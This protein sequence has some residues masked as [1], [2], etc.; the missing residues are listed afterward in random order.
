MKS[1]A[2]LKLTSASRKARR[3]SRKPSLTFSAVSRPRPRSFLNASPSDRV[4]PSNMRHRL[5]RDTKRVAT[6]TFDYSKTIASPLQLDRKPRASRGY[7]EREE[8]TTKAQS[9]HKGP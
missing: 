4:M 5:D 8:F 9:E 3:T 7:D 6:A 1:L 2:T